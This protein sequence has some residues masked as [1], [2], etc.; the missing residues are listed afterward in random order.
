[1]VISSIEKFPLP[2]AMAALAWMGAWL[3][4]SNSC[5]LLYQ[6]LLNNERMVNTDGERI[7]FFSSFSGSAF[8]SPSFAGLSGTNLRTM[9]LMQNRWSFGVLKPSPLKR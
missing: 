8:S 3:I 9:P 2:S 1:M 6:A 5:W 4:F 7:Y